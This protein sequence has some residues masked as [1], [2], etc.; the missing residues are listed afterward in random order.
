MPNGDGEL[1][2]LK[3]IAQVAGLFAAAATVIYI[4]GGAVLAMRLAFEDLPPDAVVSQLPKEFLIA[5]GLLTVLLPAL[6]GAA[7]YGGWRLYDAAAPKPT[8]TLG[9]IKR[10]PGFVLDV[11]RWVAKQ[12]WL[13]AAVLVAPGGLLEYWKDGWNES[14]GE[15]RTSFLIWLGAAY[16]VTLTW[17][18]AM[19]GVRGMLYRRYR[20]QWQAAGP[21]TLM[22]TIYAATLVPGAVVAG[23]TLQLPDT[24]VCTIGP[25]QRD[26]ALVG[27]TEHHIYLGEQR[28]GQNR[29]QSRRIVAV[30]TAHV[31][32]VFVGRDADTLGCDSALQTAASG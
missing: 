30:P 24:R 17:C 14:D 20:S 26:G 1:T 9:W 15:F 12:P 6:L 25:T 31:T 27:E 29:E 4:S 13:L 32:E 7:L 3:R 18:Y 5:Y 19:L 10:I 16:V 23:A 11:L 8:G 28:E 22:C 2:S 21:I